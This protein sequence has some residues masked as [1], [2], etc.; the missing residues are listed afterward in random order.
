MTSSNQRKKKFFFCDTIEM[1]LWWFV[2]TKKKKKIGGAN[3]LLLSEMEVE[4]VGVFGANRKKKTK[5]GGRK[6]LKKKKKKK[7]IMEQQSLY[8][9]LTHKKKKQTKKKNRKKW[10]LLGVISTVVVI[11]L[12]FSII[13]YWW[14]AL[15]FNNFQPDT[16]NRRLGL[17]LPLKI[18][19]GFG[20]LLL[21]LSNRLFSEY[22]LL[23]KT[24]IATAAIVAHE[25]ISGLISRYINGFAT[26][27]YSDTFVPM[28]KNYTSLEISAYW[29][30]S[31]FLLFYFL[32]DS[33]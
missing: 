24:L 8:D 10:T 16:F 4:F 20:V 12:V 15:V 25:C 3:K 22:N 2:Q 1:W 29:F 32:P 14:E 18:I 5:T 7:K 21:I 13:G 6:D 28:C 9:T 30:I 27:D 17:C 23:L 33:H 11:V 31:I 26:W 19:Y